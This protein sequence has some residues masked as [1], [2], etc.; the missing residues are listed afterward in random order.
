TD[1]TAPGYVAF[2]E[3][4]PTML[5]TH[6][7]GGQLAGVSVLARTALDRGGTLVLISADMLVEPDGPRE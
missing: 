2:V 1:P 7:D 5:L 6:V 3:P 4:T